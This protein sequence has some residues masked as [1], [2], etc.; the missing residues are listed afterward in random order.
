MKQAKRLALPSQQSKTKVKR[1]SAALKRAPKK[2]PKTLTFPIQQRLKIQPKTRLV[3]LL[4]KLRALLAK[5]EKVTS[6]GLLVMP[7]KV[8]KRQQVKLK[9]LQKR[10]QVKPKTLQKRQQVKP[11]TLRK[12]QQVKP[13][14]PRKKLHPMV[15]KTQLKKPPMASKIP[16][17]MPPT[18][19][20]IFQC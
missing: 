18:V 10:Q 1:Q 7:K 3:A 6:Q 2:L 13:R 19:S 14:T 16:P 8:Q 15:L 11:K 5:Q 12:K 4:A 20:Q 9:T 17:K